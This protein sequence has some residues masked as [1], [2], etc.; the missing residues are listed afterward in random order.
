MLCTHFQG[1]IGRIGG[2]VGVS[3]HHH[4]FPQLTIALR[5]QRILR[6]ESQSVSAGLFH[7]DKILRHMQIC[8]LKLLL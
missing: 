6:V 1:L 8:S 5:I 4:L 3:V 2:E 7:N